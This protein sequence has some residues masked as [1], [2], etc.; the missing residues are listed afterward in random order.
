MHTHELVEEI[1]RSLLKA[2]APDLL[3]R[4]DPDILSNTLIVTVA[5]D[6]ASNGGRR[7]SFMF[8]E[9]QM[10]CLEKADPGD[11]YP[12]RPEDRRRELAKRVREIFEPAVGRLIGRLTP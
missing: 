5:E 6:Y 12:M 4:F 9:N 2:R 7:F 3:V 11:A 8:S 1:C 10:R